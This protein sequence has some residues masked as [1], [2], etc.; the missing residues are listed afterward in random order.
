[1]DIYNQSEIKYVIKMNPNNKK[2]KFYIITQE[3]KYL[4]Q[5]NIFKKPKRYVLSHSILKLICFIENTDITVVMEYLKKKFK[6]FAIIDD[7]VYCDG[8]LYDGKEVRYKLPLI[9]K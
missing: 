7:V 1:M 4:L 5:G 6:H 9:I 2:G 3:G 8:E